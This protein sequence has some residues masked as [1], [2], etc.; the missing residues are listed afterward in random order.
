MS[1]P[2]PRGVNAHY[3]IAA[4]A[5][6]VLINRRQDVKLIP[7]LLRRNGGQTRKVYPAAVYQDMMAVSSYV[8]RSIAS[9]CAYHQLAAMLV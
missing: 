7:G 3:A 8:S 1:V 2:P 9:G 5:L 4:V 6:T